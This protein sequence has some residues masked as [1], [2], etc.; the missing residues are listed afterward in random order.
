MKKM[1][2]TLFTVGLA[3]VSNF[4]LSALAVPSFSRQ[5]GIDCQ[6]CHTQHMAILNDF[7]QSFKASGYRTMGTQA[8]IESENL[9]I[10][11]SLNASMLLKGRYQR[12]NGSDASGTIP[13]TSTNGGQ[14]QFPD[15]FSLY[16]GGR[17]A[18]NIGF[19]FEGNTT[20]PALV[21]AFKLPATIEI[22]DYHLSAT[23]FMTTSFGSSYSYEQASTGAVRNIVWA[24][25][26]KEIS[27]QQYLGT[28]GA[29]T[30]IALIAI[31]NNGYIN[32]SRWAPAFTAS[33]G[34]AQMFRSTYLRVAA[35]PRIDSPT[36]GEMSI[37][38]G[39]QLWAGENYAQDSLNVLTPVS[40]RAMAL[41]AQLFSSYD[42]HDFA[43]FTTWAKSPGGS[44]SRPNILNVGA[45]KNTHDVAQYRLNERSAFT[46]GGD[47]SVLPNILH[48]GGAF[49][50]AKTG[51]NTGALAV[52]GTNHSDNA[53]TLT[54]VYSLAQNIELQ[55]NHSYYFGTLYDVAQPTGKL[56]S[57]IMLQAAW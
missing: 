5:T 2:R 52:I 22:N 14:W 32:F 39:G 11:E 53:I 33:S 28:D 36:L 54:A 35:T 26:R 57:T 27:A 21:S 29:A 41:D 34:S 25:H 1:I 19:F 23:P 30:G 37:H 49:R 3:V 56:L 44:V 16:F 43:L 50:A 47:Y 13:G 51:G 45:L 20:A 7:G 9:S 42:G 46:I 24:E 38:A 17:I 12:S 10:P 18:S 15:E 55:A 6:G 48:V 31:N 4:P 40:T 8:R